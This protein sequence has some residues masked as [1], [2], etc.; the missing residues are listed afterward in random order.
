[1][2]SSVK[3]LREYVELLVEID[4]Q[5][6]FGS[7]KS[8]FV[9]PVTDAAKVASGE[10]SKTA[11]KA[12]GALAKVSNALTH[13]M[14]PTF[15]DNKFGK[16]NDFVTKKIGEIEAQ[17]ASA[18]DNITPHVNSLGQKLL[19]MADPTGFIAART[20]KSSASEIADFMRPFIANLP[21]ADLKN[22]SQKMAEKY[23]MG[24]DIGKSVEKWLLKDL[25][26][27][28]IVEAPV[29]DDVMRK[30]VKTPE[31]A[32]MVKKS[33]FFREMSDDMDT[34]GRTVADEFN[35]IIDATEKIKTLDDVKR[36]YG[37]TLPNV[38]LEKLREEGGSDETVIKLVK[39]YAVGRL[40]K[41]I[42]DHVSKIGLNIDDDNAYSRRLRDTLSKAKKLSSGK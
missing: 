37:V 35:K 27:G 20:A 10:V 24:V 41:S 30:I 15:F 12:S 8:T 5:K 13:T 32:E 1:M 3:L 9:D 42:E 31:F 33:A 29:S 17:N 34:V 26:E 18:W 39:D 23:K 40:V 6:S 16:I 22:F 25:R 2:P 19:F 14:L 36:V 28:L 21:S 38:D 11:V 4:P 7:L